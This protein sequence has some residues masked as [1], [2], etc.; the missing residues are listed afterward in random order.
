MDV[1]CSSIFTQTHGE[2]SQKPEARSQKRG[3]CIGSPEWQAVMLQSPFWLQ[4]S[5]FWLPLSLSSHPDL[6]HHRHTRP[7][8]ALGVF[9]FKD[10]FDGNPLHDFDVIAGRIFRRQ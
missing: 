7:E 5:G 10:N 2:G 9:A 6:D 8:L 4:A 1:F 3:P